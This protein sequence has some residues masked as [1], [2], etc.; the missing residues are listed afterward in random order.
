[1]I[2]K[3]EALDY[4]RDGRSGK[5]QVIPT[6][7]LLTQRDLALAYSPG[8][9]EPCREIHRNPDD[10]YEYTAKGNLVAVVSNG[11]AVLGLGNIGPL[12]G[13]PVMEGKA[14]LF[15]KF[16]DIDVFDI[17]LD[18][19]TPEEVIAAVK[20]IAPTFG[21]I[22]LEDIRSPDC[23]FIERT[24]RE[25]LDIPVFHDD[26]HGTAIIAAAALLNAADLTGRRLPDLKMV[27]SGAG[28][29]A[30]ATAKLCVSLGCRHENIW[31]FDSLGLVYR[32]REEAMFPEKEEFAQDHAP[33]PI[34]EALVGADVFVGLSVGGLLKPEM[35]KGMAPKPIIFAMANPDP[36]ISYEDAKQAVPDAIGA[37]GR[38]DYPNQVNNVLGFPFVFRGALDCRARAINEEMKMAA[39]RALAE[40]AREDVPDVVLTAYDQ[41]GISFGSEYLIPKPFDPRVLLWVAPAVARA[42]EESGVARRPIQDY[43]VYREQLEKMTERTR[44]IIRPMMNRARYNLR[45]IIMPDGTNPRLLR[46]AQLM[47]DERLCQPVLLGPEWKIQHRARAHNV[48]LSGIEIVEVEDNEVFDTFARELWEL[49]QRKGLTMQA[50]R[51]LLRNHT[52]YGCMMLRK[53]SAHGLLGGLA[54]PYAHTI[55]PALQILDR[56]PGVKVISGAYAMLFEGRRVFFGDCTVNISP[57]A[58]TLAQIAINTAQVARTFGVEPRVAMLSYSDFGE[59]R[60]EEGV[61]RVREALSIVRRLAPDLHIDGE[62][63]ADTAINPEKA[64]S[65]FPFSAIAGK[66]NVLIF[67]DLS[68]GNIAYKLLRDL[69]GATALGPIISGLACPVNAL[70]LGSKVADIVNMATIT[71]NQILDQETTGQLGIG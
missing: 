28:A 8:V 6:K 37:T 60:G 68:S 36:E 14:N 21:G 65:D 49:R 41:E 57:D 30:V 63:Q 34:S 31:M 45:R 58:A 1:M 2:T 33:I 29:A 32:G 70:P 55:R 48:D 25:Q 71:V 18:A 4:H 50:A 43:D 13:K 24:L 7:P 9:A 66:A 53:G 51:H 56:A 19:E 47:V 17:E 46:A 59:S 20:A 26:Q 35:V 39:V 54:T 62:M 5:L 27:F 52:V 16:A 64:L 42:A 10:A 69:G 22:N 40:L 38:S 61:A 44:E 12:A 15:K 23:F 11:T 3:K 67:P